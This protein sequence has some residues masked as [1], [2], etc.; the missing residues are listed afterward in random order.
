MLHNINYYIRRLLP[1][2]FLFYG[3]RTSAVFGSW[4]RVDRSTRA[5]ERATC[6]Y[7]SFV[8]CTDFLFFFFFRLTRITHTNTQKSWT[9][10]KSVFFVG[11]QMRTGKNLAPY[12]RFLIK[13]KYR[14]RFWLLSF[15]LFRRS[16]QKFYV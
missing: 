16:F 12:V 1:V 2:S 15:F 3:R 14:F 4:C 9:V 8:C 11:V 5:V 6:H 10:D 7:V 13:H